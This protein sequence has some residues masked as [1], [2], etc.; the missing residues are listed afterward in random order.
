[1]RCSLF[2][3][4]GHKFGNDFYYKIT[5]EVINSVINRIVS[6]F[7][8]R[9]IKQ[10]CGRLLF[11]RRRATKNEI[12]DKYSSHVIHRSYVKRDCQRQTPSGNF[13]TLRILDKSL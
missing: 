6:A 9:D 12:L 3:L 8:K 13:I 4:T 5:P 11:K 7:F 1:M 2:S 10:E